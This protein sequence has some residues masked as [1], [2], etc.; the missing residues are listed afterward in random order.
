M[1]Q[2]DE[3]S[4]FDQLP[5][6]MSWEQQSFLIKHL[7]MPVDGQPVA[8]EDLFAGLMVAGR[9]PFEEFKQIYSRVPR[10]GIE[11]VIKNDQRILLTKREIPPYKG[12]W[13]IPGGAVLKNE[14]LHQAI[15]RVAKE[16]LGVQDLEIGQSFDT[17]EYQPGYP[18]FDW[19]VSIAFP[20][21]QVDNQFSLNHESSAVDWFTEIPEKVIPQQRAL[22]EQVLQIS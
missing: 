4:M 12:H 1:A 8:E 10:P 22:I 6:Q 5:E 15:R 7:G 11:L 2:S 3:I 16:E 21:K 17:V 19:P 20:A 18:H 9:I 14:S 13:H